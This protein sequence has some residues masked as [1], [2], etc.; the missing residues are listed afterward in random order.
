MD[1][2]NGEKGVDSSG[3]SVRPC[4]STDK[5]YLT[6]LVKNLEALF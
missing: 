2:E 4:K 6:E 5:L 3:S 1:A